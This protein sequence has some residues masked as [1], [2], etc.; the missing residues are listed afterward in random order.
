M[1]ISPGT[2]GPVCLRLVFRLVKIALL[3]LCGGGAQ[4][5]GSKLLPLP[6]CARGELRNHSVSFE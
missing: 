5:M 3:L 1:I 6:V 2:W 4:V